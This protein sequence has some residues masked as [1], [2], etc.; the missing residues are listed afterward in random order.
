[1]EEKKVR[2]I[3]FMYFYSCQLLR[4]K[5]QKFLTNYLQLE[6]TIIKNG[7]TL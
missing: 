6:S 3:K 1:M 7:N 2:D 5:T 4:L